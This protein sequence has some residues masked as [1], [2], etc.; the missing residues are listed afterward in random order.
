MYFVIYNDV[1]LEALHGFDLFDQMLEESS[2]AW[3]LGDI[4]DFKNCYPNKL[5]KL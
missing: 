4:C 5:K 3:L 2:Q 1:H